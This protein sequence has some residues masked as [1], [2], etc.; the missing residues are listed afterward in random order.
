M[1][2]EFIEELKEKG[3]EISFSSGKIKYKGPGESITP[4]ILRKLKEFKPSLIRYLWPAECTNLMPI[5][6][7]GTKVPFILVYF[8]VM[9]YP[10]SEYLGKDQPF[11]GFLHYGSRGEEIKYKSVE[12]FAKAYI[13]QL[14]KVIPNGPYFLGGFSFGGILAYEMALQL[15]N[16]GHEVPFLALLDSMS[17]H[18]PMTRKPQYGNFLMRIKKTIIGPFYRSVIYYSKILMCELSFKINKPVPVKLR[19]F[20][21]V[22][23][24][25]KLSGKYNPGKFDEEVLLFRS[26][27]VDSSE[28]Y[29]GWESLVR[30]V[31]VVPF[32]GGH[33]TI[34]RE[35]EYAELIGEAFR[36]HLKNVYHNEAH[37]Q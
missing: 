29:N 19:N 30:K 9:N 11:Y 24:Y 2:N 23:K 20:Y 1:F 8:E 15:K 5:N 36:R 34:A 35:R 10:L 16:Q 26:D 28:R 37:E 22:E 27:E 13:E 18:V 7:E 25:K 32:K 17:P 31:N 3:I 14:Q 21:I 4:D 33:L 6:S 12:E